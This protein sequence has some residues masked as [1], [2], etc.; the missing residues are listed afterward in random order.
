MVE[1]FI[2]GVVGNFS[3]GKTTL[4]RALTSESTLRHSEEKKRGITI[5]L[6][7]AH[8]NIYRCKNCNSFSRY[9]KCEICGGEAILEK[10]ISFIDAPGHKNLMTTM[11]SGAVLIDSAIMVISAI[12]HCPQPQT[13]EHMEALKIIG[14]KNIVVV[15]TKVDIAGK[16]RAKENYNEIK[17]FLESN[18]FKDVPIIPVLASANINVVELVQ[19]I[20]NIS[21]KRD[22]DPDTKMLVV[23]SFDVNKPGTPISELKGGILGGALK[24]GELAVGDTIMIHPGLMVNGKV[25]PIETKIDEIQS[26]FGSEKKV[27]RGI[28]IGVRTT[29]DPSLTRSDSLAGSLVV[30]GDIKPI[31]SDRFVMEYEPLMDKEKSLF[32]RPLQKNEEVLIN[33]LAGKSIGVVTEVRNNKVKIVLNNNMVLPFFNGDKVIVSRKIDNIWYLAGSGKITI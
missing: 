24:G 13:Q 31:V 14:I 15:Q 26:E 2:F 12:N 16:E 7:Y 27:G 1:D 3:D 22:D 23:R 19:K 6:G 33:I 17:S 20:A 9:E 4:I 10:R 21:I 29:L 8:M 18:G 28:T 30:K 32:K 5:R 25:T 11:L